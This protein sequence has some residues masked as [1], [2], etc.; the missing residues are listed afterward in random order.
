M[1]AEEN[2][3]ISILFSKISLAVLLFAIGIGS[4][5]WGF[6]IEDKTSLLREILL[7]VGDVFVI[8][9]V[10]G[11]VANAAQFLRLF[12]QELQ[13]IVYGKEFI[14][15]QKDV[16]DIWDTVSKQLFKNKFPRIH[17]EFLSVIKSYFPK[18]EV[19]YYDDYETHIKI[20]WH[21]CCRDLIKVTDSVRF[22][23]IAES[24]DKFV[25]PLITTTCV[26]DKETYHNELALTVN[27]KQPKHITIEETTSGNEICQTQKIELK[28]SKKY[29]IEYTRTKMY[30]LKDDH[31]IGFRAKYIV[32]DLRVCLEYPDDIDAQFICRGIQKE[33]RDVIRGQSK[34]KIEKRY[35]GII[36]PKQGYVFALQKI[37]N[38]Q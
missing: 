13:N 21:D 6:C 17:A 27:G 37:I 1:A 5:I 31:F 25:Y 3:I 30:S 8:G 33:F 7:K 10:V 2:K 26:K 11:F 32:K 20:E 34:N 28:G 38:N 14:G 29:E 36:L 19:S 15:K 24:E 9:V 23:L 4:Y 12:K 18:D 35:S 16:S 22:N